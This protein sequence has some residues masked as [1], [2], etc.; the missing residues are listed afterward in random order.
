MKRNIIA[1][2]LIALGAVALL[3]ACSSDYLNLTPEANFSDKDALST[4]ENIQLAVNGICLSMNTQYQS[5]NW[6]QYNGESYVNTICNDAIGQD[7]ISGLFQGMFNSE[8]IKGLNWD[9]A[10]L[11]LNVIPWDYCYGLI[12]QANKI[13]DVVDSA[14]GTDEMRAWVK[15]QTLTLRAHAYTKLLM[16]YAPRWEDSDGGE[17]YCLVY[18]TTGAIKNAPLATMNQIL[19]LIYSDLNTALDLYDKA[20]NNARIGKWGVDKSIALGTFA[21]AALIK[22]DWAT[23]QKMAHD[24]RQGYQVMDNNTYLSGFYAENNDF[25]WNSTAEDSEVYYWSWGS[26][27]AANGQYTKKW[28]VGGGAIDFDL[29]N[30]LD[31]NDIRR[32]TFFTPDKIAYMQ[33]VGKQY[34]PGKLDASAFWNAGL[35]NPATYLTVNEGP[36]ARDKNDREKPFGLYNVAVYFFR[37]YLENVFKGNLSEIDNQGFSCYYTVGSEGKINVGPG[38]NADLVVTPIGAQIKFFSYAPYGTGHYP[39]MRASEMVLA[40]AEAAY[41]NGDEN[42][43]KACLNEINGKRIPGYTCTSTGEDL[44][45]EIKLC[46][47]IELWGEGQNWSDFKRWNM[48]INRRAWIA[49]DATSGNWTPEISG[50]ILPGANYGWRFTVP[51]SESNYNPMVDRTLL[52]R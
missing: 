3:P 35:V 25:M 44:F 38:R 48:P 39:Y 47:R 33:E 5:T 29:F 4:V 18:R 42:T 34:N 13:L 11:L 21:R 52:P 37:H 49:D 10:D 28:G 8:T 46:R 41:H 27:Y 22:N 32:M 12:Q 2:G 50:E 31:E 16:F 23:A 45:N 43:A 19:D 36:T 1:K 20:G 14:E 6:N 17:K 24:A 30:Q 26:H 15:A 7:Y 9:N 51:N 40:E